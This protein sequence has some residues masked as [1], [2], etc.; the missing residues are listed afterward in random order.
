MRRSWGTHMAARKPS[1]KKRRPPL[2]AVERKLRRDIAIA[3]S[4]P[5]PVAAGPHVELLDA[6]MRWVQSGKLP[7]GTK[8]TLHVVENKAG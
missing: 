3:Y 1:H 8:P 5:E 4:T 6:I 7:A 2:R